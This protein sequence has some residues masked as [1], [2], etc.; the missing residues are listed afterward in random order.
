[1]SES[2]RSASRMSESIRIGSVKNKSIIIEV[3]RRGFKEGSGRI[4]M[5]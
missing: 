5:T 3:F 4:Q 2:L 1:M